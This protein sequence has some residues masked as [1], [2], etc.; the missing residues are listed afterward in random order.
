MKKKK[1]RKALRDVRMG[2]V[3]FMNPKSPVAEQYRTIR[4]NI[5]FSIVDKKLKT[6]ACTS[7]MPGEGKSTT[8]ANLAV[9]FVQQGKKILLIDA[10][11]RRPTLHRLMG[12][13]SE[14]GLTNLLTRRCEI[15]EA[16]VTKTR[17]SGLHVLPCGPV[18]PNP[19]EMLGSNMMKELMEELLEIYDM[20]LFDTPPVLAVTDALVLSKFCDGM[21]LV[22]RSQQTEKKDLLKAK[23][24]LDR[25]NANIIGVIMNDASLNQVTYNSY[26]GKSANDID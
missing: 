21:L 23:E 19:S 2:L 18:P 9:T 25:S 16:I 6:L 22:L 4:T 15:D 11:L 10:D 1:N 12:I 26:Y 13:E 7:P 3:S 24:L 20:I 5:E 17:I 8:V 14:I